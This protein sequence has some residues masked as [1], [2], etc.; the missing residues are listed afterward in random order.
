MFE[1]KA[2][3]DCP[4]SPEGKLGQASPKNSVQKLMS[5]KIP[6]SGLGR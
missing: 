3:K 2:E 1:V 6:S 5:A 4:V